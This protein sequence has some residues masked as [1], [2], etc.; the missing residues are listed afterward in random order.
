MRDLHHARGSA[1]GHYNDRGGTSGGDEGR[2]R[3]RDRYNE[4]DRNTGWQCDAH[5]A[6]D[7]D[8]DRGT[9]R[10][11]VYTQTWRP[12]KP[13]NHGQLNKQI[14]NKSDTIEHVRGRDGPDTQKDRG[15]YSGEDRGRDSRDRNDRNNERDRSKDFQR[16]TD[17][18]RD[19]DRDRG[20]D[21]DRQ[22]TLTHRPSKQFNIELNKQLMR[23]SDTREL[24]HFV[25]THASEFDPV[26]VATSFRQVLK[27]PFRGLPPKALAQALQTLDECALHNMQDFG[28]REIANTLHIMAKQRYKATGPLLLAMERRAEAI[29]GEFKPQEVANT[30]WAFATMGTK[31]GERMM[32]QLERRSEA[33]S[34][35][36]NSQDVANTL[37]AKCHVR[38]IR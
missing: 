35:E 6:R 14:L 17:R 9:D 4:R 26:N 16:S 13:F 27:K 32:G 7:R 34:G 24:C 2:G 19:R 33:I 30:L 3:E 10:E 11:R 37:W 21:R 29:S 22:Y 5:S 28:A 38:V 15:K 31:P 18:D 1:S 12:N 36:L 8:R 25:S 23:I 20:S